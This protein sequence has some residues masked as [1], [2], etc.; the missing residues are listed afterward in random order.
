MSYHIPPTRIVG[1]LALFA[2]ATLTLCASAA[3][4]PDAIAAKAFE[5]RLA[6]Q[7]DEA[8]QLLETG[9]AEHPQAAV[10]NYELARARL[11]LLDIEGMH[12][13]AEAAVRNAPDNSEFEYFAAL[14]SGYALID[15]AH[16]EDRAR[17]KAMGQEAMDHLEDILRVDPDNLQARYF[18]VQQSVEM[19]PEVGLE[20]GD[21]EGHVRLLEE[22]DPIMG[23]KAR[24]CLVDEKEQREIWQ[25]ILAEHPEDCRA[26]VE[27]AEGLIDVGELEL[28]ETCLTKA[29][30]KDR[31]NC[32]GL[33]RLGLAHAMREDWDQAMALTQRFLDTEPLIALKAFAM[34]RMGMIHHRMGDR[35]RGQELMNQA[36]E[37]DPHVWQ[38]VMPPPREI[39][40]PL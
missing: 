39:F 30:Q 26:L 23:A 1:A 14:A 6:G 31:Q 10:L 17:M 36:R 27:A 9:L 25:K 16:H 20:V 33:L 32:Y 11:F 2:I 21:T 38:T 37:L 4:G 28:A 34:G 29:I 18:L 13:A 15:A 12:E 3:D 40:T 24:C 7:V 5:L 8:V 22:K 35:D 19:A